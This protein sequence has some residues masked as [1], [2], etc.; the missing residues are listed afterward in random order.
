MSQNDTVAYKS[1]KIDEATH[2]RLTELKTEL[3]RTENA[4]F[5]DV[6]LALIAIYEDKYPDESETPV[7]IEYKEE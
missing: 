7:K 2:E 1:L 4:T 3:F 6:I 5:D